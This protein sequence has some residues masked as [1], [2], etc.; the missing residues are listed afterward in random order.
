MH[1]LLETEGLGGLLVRRGPAP[2]PL[3]R[4]LFLGSARRFR[5]AGRSE[6]GGYS[7]RISS[8][9]CATR[10]PDTDIVALRIFAADRAGPESRASRA[11][12]TAKDSRGSLAHRR[13]I[14][15]AHGE[16][17]RGLRHMCIVATDAMDG[18]RHT[19]KIWFSEPS[20]QTVQVPR[21]RAGSGVG[22]AWVENGNRQLMLLP[23]KLFS[24]A[25]WGFGIFYIPTSDSIV[26]AQNAKLANRKP[27]RAKSI[28]VTWSRFQTP[29]LSFPHHDLLIA[30]HRRSR[31]AQ[32]R[33]NTR[34][35]PSYQRICGS[36]KKGANPWIR[37]IP[38]TLPKP[39]L[40]E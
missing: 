29:L 25:P 39:L 36:T 23:A 24:K 18:V 27:D 26:S 13:R 14:S 38:Q 9:S 17:D 33:T 1:P 11:R 34:N 21:N 35:R 8:S 2:A 5:V 6:P 30:D 10:D 12:I 4:G 15:R 22:H 16:Y 7:R 28:H 40:F 32:G 31:W 37:Y 20:S 19:G 3:G